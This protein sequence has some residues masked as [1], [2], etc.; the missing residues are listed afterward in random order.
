MGASRS[1]IVR[2]YH[3]QLKDMVFEPFVPFYAVW[4]KLDSNKV[5][6]VYTCFL[7]KPCIVLV[8]LF[9][10]A[11]R[12]GVTSEIKMVAPLGCCPHIQTQPVGLAK[13]RTD[14]RVDR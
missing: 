9:L 11:L 7:T 14:C 8:H 13:V 4:D 2:T 10:L 6:P 12:Q 3:W 5:L 1:K